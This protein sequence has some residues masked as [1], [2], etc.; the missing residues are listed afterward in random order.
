MDSHFSFLTNYSLNF[1]RKVTN[2]TPTCHL[3]NSHHKDIKLFQQNLVELR[4]NQVELFNFL[5]SGF[6]SNNAV[7]MWVILLESLGNSE[8]ENISIFWWDLSVPKI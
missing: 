1:P 3:K 4:E 5:H 6:L 8:Q 2:F 7:K